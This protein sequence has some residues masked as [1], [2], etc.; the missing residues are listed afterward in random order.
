MIKR[1]II[2]ISL[3]FSFSFAQDFGYLD[4]LSKL[5]NFPNIQMATMQWES[6]QSQLNILR[7]PVKAELSAGYTKTWGEFTANNISKNLDSEDFNPISLNANFTVVPYGPAFE[8]IIKAEWSFK[9]AQSNLRDEKNKQII[10]L[11]KG[12]TSALV[13][14]EQIS[15][16]EAQLEYSQLRLQQAQVLLQSGTSNQSQ[17][18]QAK[19]QLQQSENN[20]E[21]KKRNYQQALLSL[22]L[23]TGQELRGVTG[24]V[25]GLIEYELNI[26]KQINQRTDIQ[27]ALIALQRAQ[28]EASSTLRNNLPYGTF[29]LA[30]NHTSDI[31]NLN[32]G[33]S[34]N[35]KSFQPSLNASYDPDFKPQNAVSGQFSDTYTLGLKLVIPLDAAL[36]EAMQLS[37]LTIKQA[38]MQIE[39]TIELAKF[40]IANKLI[41]LNSA[42]ANL[43][44]SLAIL[45]QSNNNLDITTKRFNA[46]IISELDLKQSQNSL[47]ESAIS[48]QAAKNQTLLAKM[49]LASSLSINLL[50]VI[51]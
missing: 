3:A 33:M 48:L 24:K 49:Q 43:E 13:A 46:G 32:I 1:L 15:L 45:E 26:D 47:L 25:L 35:T 10:D 41:S 14:K 31:D 5:D 37:E 6:S 51:K 11:T 21:N 39:Q 22:S 42:K 12:F 44:L 34:Y 8:Q 7:S 38:E 50:E 19:I 23:S 28:L 18:E 4:L 36:P 40:D 2:L 9:Q 20:L 17:L 16:A 30:Y 29:N 27:A